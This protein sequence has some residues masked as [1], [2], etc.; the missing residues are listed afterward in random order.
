MRGPEPVVVGAVLYDP[1][2]SVR[3]GVS[4]FLEWYEKAVLAKSR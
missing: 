3:D 1:K 2:V 4:R